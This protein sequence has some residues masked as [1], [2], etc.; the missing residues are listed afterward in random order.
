MGKAG[1]D[2]TVV[3]EGFMVDMQTLQQ[4]SLLAVWF[5]SVISPLLAYTSSWGMDPYRPL[6]P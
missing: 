3:R 2:A 6:G 5:L 4:G 1:F